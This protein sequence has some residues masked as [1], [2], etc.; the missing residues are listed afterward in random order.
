MIENLIKQREELE[1]KI[2]ELRKAEEPYRTFERIT[3]FND[4]IR[5][6]YNLIDIEYKDS[7]FIQKMKRY[8]YKTHCLL[9]PHHL[10]FNHI[11]DDSS[12]I[13]VLKT[14]EIENINGIDDVRLRVLKKFLKSQFKK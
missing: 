8:G 11:S 5:A 6:T 7:P 2:A 10:A 9:F 1:A 13:F 3:K 14:Q 12:F 4:L